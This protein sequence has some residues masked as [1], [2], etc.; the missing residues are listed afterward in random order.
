M[1]GLIAIRN[2]A[3]AILKFITIDTIRQHLQANIY[4]GELSRRKVILAEVG[5]GKVQAAAATQHLIDRYS[6]RVMISC[7]SA[8][9]VAPHLQVG[10]IIVADKVVSHDNGVQ[11]ESGLQYTGYYDNAHPDGLH[12]HRYLTADANLLRTAQQA[13]STMTWPNSQPQ[14]KSGCLASGDQVI[15]SNTKKHWLCEQFDAVAVDME[16][17][18]MAH[19]AFLNDVPWLAIRAISDGADAALDFDWPSLITYSDAPSNLPHRLQHGIAKLTA[20]V[21]NPQQLEAMVKIRKNIK[22]AAHHAAIA[23]STVVSQLE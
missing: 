1:I 16:S 12:F 6:A 19:V 20:V 21:K 14:V 18:A 13:V 15:A 3:K 2:E 22:Q 8:G 9:A 4:R 17:G 7:G 5:W 11:T 23:T 10:D